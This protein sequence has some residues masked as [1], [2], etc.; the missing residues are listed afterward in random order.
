MTG[1]F[2][3]LQ[4]GNYLQHWISNFIFIT[5]LLPYYFTT[6]PHYYI[7][8]R[9]ISFLLQYYITFYYNTTLL[10]YYHTT[11]L[12]CYLTILLHYYIAA[13]LHYFITT[14]LTGTFPFWL[15]KSS[16]R[17]VK[18]ASTYCYTIE[19]NDTASVSRLSNK[20]INYRL[21]FLLYYIIKSGISSCQPNLI[22]S[23]VS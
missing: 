8:N 22:T 11:L 16:I 9:Y 14:L 20:T 10:H 4:L 17:N 15:I 5:T 2:D 13:L 21:I 18:L 3:W 12:H 7:S 19:S 6:L 1:Q 23:F